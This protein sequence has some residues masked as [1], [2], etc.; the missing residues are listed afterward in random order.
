MTEATAVQTYLRFVEHR[1]TADDCAPRWE[2]WH[3]ASVLVGRRA[4]FRLKWAATKLHLFTA[5]AAVPEITVPA[6][7][8]FTWQ[9]L[10]YARANKGGLPVGLQ[11][12]I[13]AFPVLVSERVDP[14]A[15]AWAQEQQRMRFACFARPV[16]V[17]MSKGHVGFY[18]DTPTL[19]RVYASHLLDKGTRYFQK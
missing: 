19:G 15:M 12:G 4:D 2:Q 6:V 17:D 13:A 11:T 14:A 3:G 10:D 7:E 9:V 8:S 5:V 18:R 16:V 1:L